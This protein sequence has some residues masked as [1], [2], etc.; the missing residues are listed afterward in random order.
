MSQKYYKLN[1]VLNLLKKP[2]HIRGLSK[3]LKTNQTTIARK[4]K[5]L[6]NDNVVDYKQEGRNKVYF[7]KNALEAREY[8][9]ISEHHK[10][11]Q[12]L[13]KYPVLRKIIKKIK[14]HPK[15]K[16]SILFGSYAKGLAH[17]DSDID[18]YIETESKEIKKQIENINTKLNVKIGKYNK[19]NILI[20]EIEKNHIIIKGVETYY[21]KNEFF[22]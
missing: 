4:L 8:V 10:L 9:F 21:E 22:S 14:N 13:R 15:I 17:K 18:I 12:T 2:N 20:K 11:I 7:I 6:K 3:D 1:I 19:N 16:L 5:E